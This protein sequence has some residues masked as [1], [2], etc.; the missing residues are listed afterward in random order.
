MPYKDKEARNAYYHRV[1]AP[2]HLTE[3]WRKNRAPVQQRFYLSQKIRVFNRL[4]NKCNWPGC[5]W[6][7]PRVLQIDHIHG[8]GHEERVKL[9]SR[10]IYGK[11][12]KM[13]NPQ[14][15]Y[16]LLCANHNWIKR[17]ENHE[18]RWTWLHQPSNK[19]KQ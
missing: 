6:T 11:I 17:V 7:D 18:V 5:E 12:L 1:E 16:Q 4:G 15:E 2:K 3:E 13:D 19:G 8:N 10:G 14:S 9:T